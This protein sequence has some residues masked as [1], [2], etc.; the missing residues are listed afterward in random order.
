MQSIFSAPLLSNN[1]PFPFRGYPTTP[2]AQSNVIGCDPVSFGRRAATTPSS[3]MEVVRVTRPDEPFNEGNMPGFLFVVLR[4]D[5]AM[6]ASEE[7]AAIMARFNTIK[8]RADASQHVEEVRA[9]VRAARNGSSRRT[10]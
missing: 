9:K 1:S 5:L 4:S 8:T 2:P 6:S 7:R 3:G 10:R